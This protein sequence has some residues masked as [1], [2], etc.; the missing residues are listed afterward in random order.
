M[1][2]LEDYY[3]NVLV[4]IPNIDDISIVEQEKVSETV[5]RYVPVLESAN[6]KHE[7]NKKLAQDL[8]AISRK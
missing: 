8:I 3:E 7:L 5:D 6:L 2:I 4:I 1:A